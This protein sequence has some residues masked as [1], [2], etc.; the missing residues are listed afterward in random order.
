[1]E[2]TMLFLLLFTCSVTANLNSSHRVYYVLPYDKT[3]S[4]CPSD[5]IDNCHTL[6]FFVSYEYIYLTT[7]ATLIF[8]EGEHLLEKEVSVMN[9]GSLI[10]TSQW[11][12]ESHG[13]VTIVCVNEH[14]GFEFWYVNRIEIVGIKVVNCSGSGKSI[15][16][17][18]HIY[19]VSNVFLAMVSV[20]NGTKFGLLSYNTRVLHMESCHFTGIGFN[21]SGDIGG[22]NILLASLVPM[23]VEYVITNISTSHGFGDHGGLNIAVYDSTNLSLTLDSVYAHHNLAIGPG[24]NINIEITNCSIHEIL[25]N[26]ITSTNGRSIGGTK[27]K[28]SSGAGLSLFLNQLTCLPHTRIII[29]ECTVT[30]NSA[31]IN[32]GVGIVLN[33]AQFCLLNITHNNVSSNGFRWPNDAFTKLPA[34]IGGGGMGI[35]SWRFS[36]NSEI[37][38][39][40]NYFSKN[41][42][43]RG[44]ALLY[45]GVC[46][47]DIAVENSVFEGNFGNI[48]SA[49]AFITTSLSPLKCNKSLKLRLVNV[50]SIGNIMTYAF[51]EK[52][53]YKGLL[54]TGLTYISTSVSVFTNILLNFQVHDITIKNNYNTSGMS[55]YGCDVTF[56]GYKNEIVNN[57]SPVI[58]GGLIISSSNSFIVN[59]GSHVLFANNTAVFDGGAVFVKESNNDDAYVSFLITNSYSSC[60]FKTNETSLTEDSAPLVTFKGNRAYFGAG[61]DFYGGTLEYCYINKNHRINL[62]GL[63]CPIEQYWSLSH[64]SSISSSPIAVC[65]CTNNATTY[66]CS[67][68]ESRKEIYPGQLFNV[69]LVTVGMCKG[70]KKGTLVTTMDNGNLTTT[71]NDQQTAQKCKQFTY[72]ATPYAL[73]NSSLVT[74]DVAR[75]KLVHWK[76]LNIHIEYLKCPDG[77]TFKPHLQCVCNDAIR[78]SSI[79][80]ECNINSFPYFKRLGRNWIGYFDNYN[81][82]VAHTNCPFDY[83]NPSFLSFNISSPHQQCFMNRT[84]TLCGRCHSGLSLMLGSNRCTL[85]SN[86]YL[87]LIPAFIV[88]GILFIILLMVF[89]LTVSSGRINGIIFY[90]NIVKL[91]DYHRGSNIPLLTQFISWLNLDLGIETCFYSGLDG[92][93]KTWLQFA[94]PLYLWVLAICI[95]FGC[96]HSLRLSRYCGRNAVPVLATVLLMTYTKILRNITDA[97]MFTNLP[98]KGDK[99][100]HWVLWSIDPSIS[101]FSSKHIALFIVSLLLLIT[102]LAYTMLVFSTQWIER[103]SYKCFRNASRLDPAVRLKPLIDAYSGPYRDNCRYWTGLLMI[104]RVF[105]TGVFTFTTGMLPQLNISIIIG[106]VLMLVS[107]A[108]MSGGVYMTKRMNLLELFSYLNVVFISLASQLPS[109]T[110]FFGLSFSL[111]LLLLIA[112]AFSGCFFNGKKGKI[113]FKRKEI[114]TLNIEDVTVDD[115]DELMG[116]PANV[117]MRRESLIF[118]FY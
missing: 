115:A 98:C 64:K 39:S 10:L 86:T 99:T 2:T 118:D 105:L 108:W 18:L 95:I 102:S 13:P 17:A 62:D 88:A 21:K 51:L 68:R 36:V 3:R 19:G 112:V 76:T 22:G 109:K 35:N 66:N 25:L 29:S 65:V 49:I 44:A 79:V 20:E 67:A 50:S 14:G 91:N 96:R 32:S 100:H 70:V 101:Y 113:C 40:K 27:M 83:C 58:G 97:L 34:A 42:A 7:N 31:D 78:E 37:R 15:S 87:S 1:M 74:I 90:A 84:G 63:A 46:G 5:G 116:S 26:N 117:I 54:Y 41:A 11:G 30:N 89:D 93:W 52:F 57:N 8:L 92:Y 24:G 71:T 47:T 103:Y 94:F 55:I 16:S 75:T 73:C 104:I 9:V 111:C 43:L 33:E 72:S 81:C 38:L 61:D 12:D 56:T 106:C 28:P 53:V 23:K 69:S 85:C 107:L 6:S 82:T 48:G 59:Q 114:A 45:D 110:V 60:S 4:S 77:F 80:T